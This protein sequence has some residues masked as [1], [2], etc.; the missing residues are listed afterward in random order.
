MLP[1][2]EIE[3]LGEIV[4]PPERNNRW[5]S[6]LYQ[7]YDRRGREWVLPLSTYGIKRYLHM[8]EGYIGLGKL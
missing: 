2:E 1:E 5:G 4:F 7:C 3:F 8:V 6:S